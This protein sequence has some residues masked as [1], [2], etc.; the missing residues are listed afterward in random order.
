MTHPLL[1]LHSV[2][3]TDS[4]RRGFYTYRFPP[5]FAVRLPEGRK[6]TAL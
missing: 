1:S 4:C 5:F 3:L 6:R 2:K